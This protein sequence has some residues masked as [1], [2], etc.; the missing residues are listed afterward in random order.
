MTLS[1]GRGV[2]RS[3]LPDGERVAERSGGRVRGQVH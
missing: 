2:S 3:P 1:E